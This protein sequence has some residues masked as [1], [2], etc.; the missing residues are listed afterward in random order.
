MINPERGI[1]GRTLIDAARYFDHVESIMED[2][3]SA[4]GAELVYGAGVA[5]ARASGA[6]APAP[7]GQMYGEILSK[8]KTLHNA[9]SWRMSAAHASKGYNPLDS[10]Y[11]LDDWLNLAHYKRFQE[12]H[13]GKN[14]SSREGVDNSGGGDDDGGGGDND[15]GG[16]DDGGGGEDGGGGDEGGRSLYQDVL[17]VGG[18]L[19]LGVVAVEQ[20]RERWREEQDRE[21]NYLLDYY[22]RREADNPGRWWQPENESRPENMDRKHGP[23]NMGRNH[24]LGDYPDGFMD[25]KHGPENQMRISGS[26]SGSGSGSSG[27]AQP[28]SPH[29]TPKRP[30]PNP[31][32][33]PSSESP[34]GSDIEVLLRRAIQSSNPRVQAAAAK[35][36]KS[37]LANQNVYPRSYVHTPEEDYQGGSAGVLENP[38]SYTQVIVRRDSLYVP[39]VENLG[40]LDFTSPNVVRGSP[41]EQVLQAAIEQKHAEAVRSPR[42]QPELAEASDQELSDFEDAPLPKKFS[43][44]QTQVQRFQNLGAMTRARAASVSARLHGT[45]PRV[46]LSVAASYPGLAPAQRI[47]PAILEAAQRAARRVSEYRSR[48]AA[49]TTKE[50]QPK[51]RKKE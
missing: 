18:A 29:I 38:P 7:L 12:K 19:G 14:A 15:G 24:G 23:E 11:S 37:C 42:T 46:P 21:R 48:R 8:I 32:L 34:Q 20:V 27:P 13:N 9:N 25:R 4:I 50:Q 41:F 30:G 36:L 28:S 10:T 33:P 40:R 51:R 26:G 17:G 1:S 44:V 43:P 6:D 2:A 49:D 16:D 47:A 35:Y 45:T 3:D 31:P 39:P 5:E 22:R